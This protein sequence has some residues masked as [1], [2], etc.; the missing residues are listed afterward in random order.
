MSLI[1]LPFLEFSLP[2][3]VK[4]EMQLAERGASLL[5]AS[6]EQIV[7]PLKCRYRGGPDACLTTPRHWNKEISVALSLNSI[8]L[9]LVLK[10]PVSCL[11]GQREREKPH[12]ANAF[13]S[14]TIF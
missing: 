2:F 14:S 6:S 13:N 7:I 9:P 12:L 4:L 5:A 11:F 1:I 10:N 8:V 3:L